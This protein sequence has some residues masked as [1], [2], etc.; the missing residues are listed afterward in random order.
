MP[1]FWGYTYTTAIVN[2]VVLL[3]LKYRSKILVYYK[4]G[5]YKIEDI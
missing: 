5:M 3:Y 1:F 2:A 4:N